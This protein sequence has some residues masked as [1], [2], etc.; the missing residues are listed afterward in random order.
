MALGMAA[1]AGP[2]LAAPCEGPPSSHILKVDVSGLKSAKGQVAVTVYPDV[3]G[4]FLA[5]GGKL[6]RVRTPAITPVT[7]ACF[8]LPAAGVYAVAIYHDANADRDFNRTLIGLPAEGFGFSND[9][10][11]ETGLPSFKSV[12]FRTTPGETT[13]RIRMRYR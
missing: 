6:A 9:A 8:H 2:A 3:P 5:P 11:T 10:P 13:I 7:R 12:R 1:M 4:R